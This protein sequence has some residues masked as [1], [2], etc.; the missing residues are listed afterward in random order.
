MDVGVLNIDAAA[1]GTTAGTFTIASGTTINNTSGGAITTSNYPLT[2]NSF[3]FTGSNN[4]NLGTGSTALGATS[5]ITTSA[6]VLELGGVVSGSYGIVKDG[7]GALTLSGTNTFTGGLTH[8]AGILN[9]NAAAALGTTAGTFTIADGV[10]L[11]NTSGGVITT[12]NYPIAINGDFSFTG[13]N[14]IDFGTGAVTLG[15]NSIITITGSTITL[16]GVISGSYGLTKDGLGHIYLTNTANTYTGKTTIAQTTSS[17]GAIFFQTIGNV[18]GGAS[19]LGAPTTVE[20]GTIAIGSGAYGGKLMFN[21]SSDQTTD[22]VIDLA[23][24]T[25]EVQISSGASASL[26]FTSDFTTTGAGSKNL[27]LRGTSTGNEIQGAIVDNSGSNKTSLVKDESGTWILTGTNTYT[28]TTTIDNGILQIGNNGTTG[29]IAS[30]SVVN[31]ASLKFYRSDDITYSGVVSSA[32]Q[33]IKEGAGVLTLTGV[34]T[35]AGKTRTSEGTILLGASGVI[36]DASQI[37]FNGGA[38][39]TGSGAGF[40]ETVGTMDVN[41]NSTLQLGS[42]DHTLTFAA[43]NAVAFTAGKT[44][45]IEGWTGPFDGTAETDAEPKIFVGSA[46]TALTAGQLEQIGFKNGAYTYGSSLLATGELVAAITLLPVDLRFFSVF[47]VGDGVMVTWETLA[48]INCD[49]FVIERSSDGTNWDQI[50]N[51][52]GSGNSA[53]AIYYSQMDND[54]IDGVSYYR[55]N[56]VD[57]DGTKKIYNP[58]V[59]GSEHNKR[60]AIKVSPNPAVGDVVVSFKTSEE[61][62]YRFSVITQDGKTVYETKIPGVKGTNY[63]DYNTDF[64]NTGVYLFMISDEKGNKSQERVVR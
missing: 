3:T 51:V 5:T 47:E 36:P 52:P 48:E 55:L 9:I 14:S 21:G 53:E 60:L 49:Y 13:D 15:A 44:L 42:G 64:L 22:R 4:L 10:T 54:P 6:G 40:S 46:N 32:G 8:N 29:S 39:S 61:E 31:G 33:I 35:Y 43:S 30:A 41:E 63:F 56:Q 57:Y 11:N 7:A 26:T 45:T 16:G 12:S 59:L 58:V 28:G 24:T 38:L 1:L 19:T 23:S 34:N 2:V 25:G 27:K 62:M 37:H 20:N 17:V 50:M 18:G